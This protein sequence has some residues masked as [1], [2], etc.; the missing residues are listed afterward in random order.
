MIDYERCITH[1]QQKICKQHCDCD[2]NNKPILNK[3]KTYWSN[4]KAWETQPN[5]MARLRHK[6]KY[7]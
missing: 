7:R 4:K 6:Y 3:M 5:W 1:A 2:T